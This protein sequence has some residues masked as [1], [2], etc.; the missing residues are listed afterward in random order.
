MQGTPT[1]W[2][3]KLE[4]DDQGRVTAW[5]PLEHHCGDVAAV[6]RALLA[7]PIWRKRLARLCGWSDLTEVHCDRLAVLAALHDLGKYNHG[8]QRKG[9]PPFERTAGHV[10]E[11]LGLFRSPDLT[12]RLSDAVAWKDIERFGASDGEAD[13]AARLLIA[14]IGHHGQPTNLSGLPAAAFHEWDDQGPYR[15]TAWEG[16]RRLAASLRQ[17]LPR[18]FSAEAEPLPQST[19]LEHAFAGLVML[20]DWLGSNREPGCFPFSESPDAQQRWLTSVRAAQESLRL[21]GLDAEAWRGEAAQRRPFEAICMHPPRP[22]QEAMLRIPASG[23]PSITILEAETGSGKTEGA[24]AHF[25]ALFAA[26]EVDGLYFALPTRTSATQMHQRVRD[27]VQRAFST[28]PAPPVVL[29]VPGYLRVDDK[30]ARRLPD[31]GVLWPDDLAASSRTTRHRGWAVENSKRYMAGT[32]V[33]GT[34]DQ[35]LLAG[36]TVPHAHL[37]ATALLRHLLVVDEVHASDAYMTNVLRCVLA[38]HAAAGGHALLMSATL[39]QRTWNA[40]LWPDAVAG[41]LPPEAADYPVVVH[42]GASVRVETVEQDHGVSQRELSLSTAPWLEDPAAVAGAALQAA[43]DGAAVLVVRNSVAEAVETQRALEALAA[44][45][46][47]ADVLFR[48]GGAPALHHGRY[49]RSD[50]VLLDQA[51]EAQFGK[52]RK[53]AGRVAVATQTIQQSLDLDADFMLTDLSPVD[54]LLQRLG[55][56]H[57]HARTDRAPPFSRPAA[58]VVVPAER[59]LG[60]F[61]R[62]DHAATYHHGLGGEVYEDLR[63]LEATWRAVERDPVWRIPQM[64]RGLVE[65][66]VDEARLRELAAA[67]GGE[68]QAHGAKVEGVYAAEARVA[69]LNL[70]DWSTSYAETG[71]PSGGDKK[72]RS[73]LG[74]MDRRVELSEPWRSPLGGLVEEFTVR[75]HW[76]ADADPDDCRAEDVAAGPDRLLF[77]FG[78]TRFVYDRWGLRKERSG[79]GEVDDDQV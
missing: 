2:W 42:R 19:A 44:E 20:A 7:L 65:A 69:E 35:A 27:A 78:G 32:I 15:R 26:R 33:V 5:H 71:F 55:R 28:G 37:R 25:M 70:V 61:I 52:G 8:F 30:D 14:A 73:R 64:C 41:A 75:A 17:W 22:A 51:L 10:K 76:C 79:R 54:V 39:G 49:A 31:F 12:R 48:C 59:D 63:V 23:G 24:L 1:D 67:L 4:K 58:T 60:R 11:A 21:N 50:R 34:V 38:H 74:L 3:A 18:A 72:V 43:R 40:L 53:A 6:T 47:C 46:A 66:C 29:A 57:R 9:I 13:A 36:L 77:S 56:L 16:V 68:W 62:S 45:T